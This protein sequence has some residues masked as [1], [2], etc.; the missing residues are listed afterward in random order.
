MLLKLLLDCISLKGKLHNISDKIV[1]TKLLDSSKD[2]D[3]YIVLISLVFGASVSVAGHDDPAG[4]GCT[5]T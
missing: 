5:L 2:C 3:Y 1:L 4:R